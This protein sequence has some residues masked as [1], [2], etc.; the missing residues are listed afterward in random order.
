MT[1][2][3]ESFPGVQMPLLSNEECARRG[4]EPG[5]FPPF[6]AWTPLQQEA[7][8]RLAENLCKN[9]VRQAYNSMVREL[10]AMEL[11]E[12][13]PDNFEQEA[14]RRVQRKLEAGT[15]T[16]PDTHDVYGLER[17]VGWAI[18]SILFSQTRAA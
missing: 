16:A 18:A 1:A 8:R 15:W 5:K 2:T 17:E 9:A 7:G 11:E 10:E 4:I 13:I 14:A 6:E 3:F 12:V